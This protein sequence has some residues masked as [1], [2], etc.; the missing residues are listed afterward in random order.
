MLEPEAFDDGADD[1]LFVGVEAA[2]GFEVDSGALNAFYG[3]WGL[4]VSN[5]V[6]KAVHVE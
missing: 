5:E 4:G 2:G 1:G 6:S 3:G